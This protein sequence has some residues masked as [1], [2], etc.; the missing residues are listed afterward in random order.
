MNRYI[1]IRRRRRQVGNNSKISNV[2]TSK[3]KE[4]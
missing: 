4:E 3:S 2:E 1:Q